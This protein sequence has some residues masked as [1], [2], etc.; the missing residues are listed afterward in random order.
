MANE[1][2]QLLRAYRQLFRQEIEAI[3]AGNLKIE[4]NG[5]DTTNQTLQEYE[6]RVDDL[7]A[8]VDR[9]AEERG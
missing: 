2:E 5:K 3:K 9:A 7:T 1:M 8:I 6:Q 4:R